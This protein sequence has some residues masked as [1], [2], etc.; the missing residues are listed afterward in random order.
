MAP[1]GSF[2]KVAEGKSAE[3][4]KRKRERGVSLRKLY[5]PARECQCTD[6]LDYDCVVLHSTSTAL[7]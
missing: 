2:I 1:P 6:V 4:V 5:L 7:C 3:R